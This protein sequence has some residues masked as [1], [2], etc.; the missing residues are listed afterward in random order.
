MPRG[1]PSEVDHLGKHQRDD[2][3]DHRWRYTRWP[4]TSSWNDRS[5]LGRAALRGGGLGTACAD[6]PSRATAHNPMARTTR[7]VVLLACA[8]VWL[9]ASPVHGQ[10]VRTTRL[11][12]HRA[13]PASSAHAP[14]LTPHTPTQQQD[15]PANKMCD[16]DGGAR[17]AQAGGDSFSDELLLLPLPGDRILVR[18]RPAALFASM[19]QAA[20]AGHALL[21]RRPLSPPITRQA[22]WHFETCGAQQPH[23]VLLPQAIQQ[24]SSATPATLVELSMARGR[25]VR[26]ATPARLTD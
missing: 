16:G 5:H 14:P 25:W 10:Q 6:L 8:A 4:K 18:C 11:G 21:I 24:L 9:L 13:P 7:L 19:L 3:S 17:R 20:A 2:R 26:A 12:R 15:E 23:T 1:V 22:H